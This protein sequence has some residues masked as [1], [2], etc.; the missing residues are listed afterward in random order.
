M[1]K[2]SSPLLFRGTFNIEGEPKDTFAYMKDWTKGVVFINGHNLGRYWDIGPQETLYLPAPWLHT[3]ENEVTKTTA[4]NPLLF[5]FV[6]CQP[7]G[8]NESNQSEGGRGAKTDP[9]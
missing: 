5:N 6:F 9:D 4:C 3:G 1:N 8:S 2:T 7:V